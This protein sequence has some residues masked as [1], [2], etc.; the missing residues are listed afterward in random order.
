MDEEEAESM[1]ALVMAVSVAG[2]GDFAKGLA[3]LKG[4]LT[5]AR[6]L[7]HADPSQ[8]FEDI[9]EAVEFAG[10][11]RSAARIVRWLAAL[12]VGALVFGG[13]IVDGVAKVASLFKTTGKLP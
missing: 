7:G 12:F 13:Q 8:G 2:D 9:R 1:R 3:V 11:V 5:L 4:Y 6:S 10:S